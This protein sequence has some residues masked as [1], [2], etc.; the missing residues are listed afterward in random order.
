MEIVTHLTKRNK[1]LGIFI[2]VRIF[3]LLTYITYLI[4]CH[5]VDRSNA[6]EVAFLHFS[7]HIFLFLFITIFPQVCYRRRLHS[8][9]LIIAQ[10]SA[11]SVS[12]MTLKN[13][14]TLLLGD[15]LPFGVPGTGP[16]G[17]LTSHFPGAYSRSGVFY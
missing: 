2:N 3:E 4:L 8:H 13:F 11:S 9:R 17:I 10:F 1:L 5:S 6:A 7:F 12:F 14:N 15:V 16:R